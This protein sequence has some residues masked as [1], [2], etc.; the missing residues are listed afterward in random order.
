MERMAAL[1]LSGGIF[2]LLGIVFLTIGLM[3]K[4]FLRRRQEKASAVTTATVVEIVKRRNR[5][6]SNGCRS[7]SYCPVYEY[8]ANGAARRVCSRVGSSPC[9]F[10]VGE[11][12]ELY[13]DPDDPAK[14]YIEK[15]ARLM[16]L[17]IVI[18][19]AVGGLFTV[20]GLGMLLLGPRL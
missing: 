14:I 13:F 2:T 17:I 9:P 11:Q 6:G 16:R 20:L 19:C 5:S 1:L 8:Y 12:L 15:E 3:M 18:F 7:T 10:H 4:K